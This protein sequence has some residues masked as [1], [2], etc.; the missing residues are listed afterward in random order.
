MAETSL[1]KK[2]LG[3]WTLV[4]LSMGSIY[5]LAFAVSNGAGAV[6]YAGFAAPVVPLFAALAILLVSVPA[7]LFSKHV[8][9]A[10]GYYGFAEKGFGLAT[11]RY[12]ALVNLLYYILMDVVSVVAVSYILSTALSALYGYTL[13]LYLYIIIALAATVLMFV[14]TVFNI[15]VSGKSVLIVVALQILIVLIFSFI[16]I[17]RTPYNSIQAFN[18]SKAPAGIT[19]VMFAAVT[20]GF[21]FFTGYGAPFYFAEE[22]K[23]SEKTVW[24]SVILSV[25]ILTAV[26]VIA[27][28]AEVAAVGISN[29]SSLANDWNPA[30]VAFGTYVGSVGTLIF[31]AIALTGQVWAGIIGGMSGA[32]LI[33]AM[34]RDK[35]L[36]PSSFA[37]THTKY[38]T[39]VVAALFELIVTSI[40]AV[41]APIALVTV[42][43]YSLGIFYSL[44]L[45]GALT[46]FMWI[47]QHLIVDAASVPFFKKLYKKLTPKVL[48]GTLVPTLAA[49]ALFIYAD[50]TAYVGIGEPYLGGLV[51]IILFL[52][53]FLIYIAYLRANKK[54]G[55][56][57]LN[58]IEA[59]GI[60]EGQQ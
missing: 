17:A 53:V 26:S 60:I 5:P 7:L 15:K 49:G 24:K 57:M 25:I 40:I 31:L 41:I 56:S 46:T 37:K 52:V 47:L 35:F 22:T 54:L 21:L 59:G 55:S 2:Q 45:F 58:S 30:V 28:Y 29:S 27:T 42:Y 51:V 34:G 19:G 23:T 6:V 8:S 13:P 33:Y 43:G 4:A 3:L 11:G 1:N 50:I 36:F 38:K 39:P 18:V 32:R 44:F 9:F 16:T 12:V 10:G 20:A 48:M 14:F